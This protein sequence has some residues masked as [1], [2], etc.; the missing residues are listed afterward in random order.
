MKKKAALAGSFTLFTPAEVLQFI[1]TSDASGILRYGDPRDSIIRAVYFVDGEVIAAQYGPK[2]GNDAL[3]RFIGF[4][5]G[6]FIF[7][8]Q[9]VTVKRNIQGGVMEL[10]MNGMRYLDETAEQ[11][12][13]KK[14]QIIPDPGDVTGFFTL[15]EMGLAKSGGQGQ[16]DEASEALKKKVANLEKRLKS[17]AGLVEKTS[18]EGRVKTSYIQ[19]LERKNAALQMRAKKIENSLRDALKEANKSGRPAN[20]NGTKPPTDE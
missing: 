19:Q 12:A 4:T 11:A 17:M 14:I 5:K 18:E 6:R 2:E 16:A 9:P 3:N 20:P 8:V 1:G 10:V 15:P 13:L 7:D